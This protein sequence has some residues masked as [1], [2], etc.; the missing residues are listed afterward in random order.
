MYA[1]IINNKFT[2]DFLNNCPPTDDIFFGYYLHMNRIKIEPIPRLD[3]HTPEFVV[4]FN[5][6]T[7]L[8]YSHYRIKTCNYDCDVKIFSYILKSLYPQFYS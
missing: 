8:N 5:I 6:N 4:N 2:N 1:F 7:D 3:A